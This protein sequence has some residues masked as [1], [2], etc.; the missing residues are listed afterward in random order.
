MFEIYVILANIPIA[1]SAGARVMHYI[2]AFVCIMQ[3]IVLSLAISSCSRLS[4]SP[5]SPNDI[6]IQDNQSPGLIEPTNIGNR[7]ILAVYDAVID[8][9]AKT[10]TIT[11]VDRSSQFHF[12]LTQLYPN[13]LKITGFGSF[14]F[15]WADIKLTHPLPG[16]GIDAF[17]PRVIAI[18]PAIQ[19]ERF[20]YPVLGVGGNNLIVDNPDGY[21]KLFDELGGSM[22]GNVNPFKAYFKSQPNR[23]WSSTGVTEETQMWV[24]NLF[25]HPDPLQFKL[26]VDIS[27]NYPNPPQPIID[28]AP[29]PVQIDAVTGTGLTP[30]GGSAPIEVTVLDWQGQPDMSPVYIEAP[31]LF[32]S[33]VELNICIP[34][35][36]PNE[37]VYSG[38][39]E[40]I[41]D[42]P[43]GKYRL[44]VTA[45]NPAT[46]IHIYNECEVIVGAIPIDG[47][48]IWAKR[49]GGTSTD[50]SSSITS[51]SDNSTV[52]VGQY[53]DS[54][55]FGPGEPNE[56]TLSSLGNNDIFIARFNRDGELEW[57][58]SVGGS[59]S[60]DEDAGYGVT[61]LSDNSVVITGMFSGSATFGQ[62]EI[63]QTVLTSA[64]LNDIFIARY[65]P[66]GSLAWVKQAGG[67]D[68]DQCFTLI[69]VS[70]DSIVSCGYFRGSAAFGS[71]N[72]NQTIL[73]SAGSCDI[74]IAKYNSD[75]T[76][77]W[78]KSAGGLSD[79]FPWGITKISSDSIV[80]AGCFSGTTTFGPGDINQAIL[81]ST[82]GNDIFIARYNSDGSIAWAKQA[83]G[84]SNDS[85][86]GI[87]STDDDS[88]VVTGNFQ[89]GA[90]FGRWEINETV[91]YSTGYSDIFVSKYNPNGTLVWVKNSGG[92]Q[93]N[94][95]NSIVALSDNS[96]VVTGFFQGTA[97]FGKSE[98][99]ETVLSTE[100]FTS[101][102]FLAR[103]NTDGTLDW[104]K[105]TGSTWYDDAGNSIA[106][107]PDNTVVATGIFWESATFGQGEINETILTSDGISDIFIAR[108]GP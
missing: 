101:D 12:P 4:E 38:E 60:A 99:N 95:G 14:P 82:G 106:R 90:V 26:V 103:Y 100:D 19:D 45:W 23:R 15:F 65:D 58:K 52:V 83:G 50:H 86:Y 43:Q 48:M 70:G 51:L 28:N 57:A 64:G 1:I 98:P 59:D 76:L 16:S 49:A 54:S 22:L 77:E 47:N 56:T 81:T 61:S 11:P 80:L 85:A 87:T 105:N 30:Y 8:P 27:T 32:N 6:S 69:R 33:L 44:L 67:V 71:G 10:F 94:S 66:D 5:L 102:V 89:N 88:I 73:T 75:G 91:L 9:V 93:F 68:N 29:E 39:I 20:I 104:A 92:N 46:G 79:E 63:N 84:L 34:G 2:K 13:V 40:N 37:Y 36:N 74:F 31:N 96:T 41:L 35:Q 42:A 7:D 18:L 78:A 25:L 108:F 53:Y 24:L 72:P 62:G 3:V 17:D 21:T 55:T 97:T 107:S